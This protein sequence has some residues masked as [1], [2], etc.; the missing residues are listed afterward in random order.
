MQCNAASSDGGISIASNPKENHMRDIN[1]FIVAC[2]AFT[3]LLIIPPE[4]RCQRERNTDKNPDQ[5]LKGNARVN[6]STLA[7]EMSILLGTYPGRA[8]ISLSNTLNYSS[9]VWQFREFEAGAFVNMSGSQG[10]GVV[11]FYAR[12]T[13]AGW[14]ST[15]AA[16]RIDYPDEFPYYMVGC[17]ADYEGAIWS[18]IDYGEGCYYD[19]YYMKR[20][21]VVMPGGL[22]HELRASDS[23][24]QC[25]S[26]GGPCNNVD[27]T[28]T[29]LS[30]D[31]SRM[32]LEVTTTGATLF[33]PDGS[34][35]LFGAASGSVLGQTATEIIDVHGNKLTYN[36]TAREWTDTIGRVLPNPLP[37]NLYTA[38][39]HNHNQQQTVG[40]QIVS[41]PGLGSET[42]EAT[43]SW[44]YLK[45]PSSS[46]PDDSGL[47]N[48]SLDLAYPADFY[49]DGPYYYLFT[50]TKLFFNNN[51]AN[52]RLCNYW[53][54]SP[55]VPFNPVVLTKVTIASGQSYQFKYNLYGEIEKI[56][57][58]S[59]GYERF[60]YAQVT[61]LQNPTA[62]YE[63][64]NRGVTDQYIS[65]NGDGT[66]EIHWTYSASRSYNN[67]PI[68][69]TDPYKVTITNPDGTK[70]E[71]LIH[72]EPDYWTQRPFGFDNAKTG[73][74][75]DEKVYS[76]DS[77]PV[78][79]SRTLTA[80]ETTGPLSGGYSSAATRDIRPTKVISITFEPGNSS[81]LAT[82]SET[83]YDTTGNSD[84]A[85]FSSLNAKQIKKY[86]YVVVSSSTAATATITTAA[87]WFPESNL[88]TLAEM[89]YL[90]DPNYKVRNING[91]VAETR[92]KD[93]N[94][95]VKAKSQ[96]AYDEAAYPV[97]PA[98]TNAQWENPNTIYRGN[99]TTTRS[100]SDVA[101]NQY[102][103]THAQYDNFGNLRKAWDA[104]GNLT[105]TDF[106][107]VYA[108][109]Y[110]SSVTT[111]IPDPSGQNGSN[112]AL[113]TSTVYDFNTGLPTSTTDV[114]SQTRT[115]EY[116]DPLLR[117]TKIIASNGQQAITEYGAG[118]SASTRWVK[119]KTQLD[120]EKWQEGYTW[121]DGL[122]RT[123]KTQSVDNAGD[124]FVETEYDNMGRPKKVTNPYRTGETIYW[125]ESFYDDLGRVTKV[126]TPDNAEV[127]TTYGLAT[128]GSEIGTAVTISDQ[129]GKLRRS[130]TNALGHLKRIDEPNDAGQLGSIDNPNQWT[131]Y[132]Y[133][134]LNNLITVN[135]D[136][137]T[138]SFTYDALSRLKSA[139]NPENGLIQ[140][141][142]DPN[143]N[144]TQ[145]TDARGIVT[146]Y[147]YD[148]LNRVK[149]RQYTNEPIGSETPDVTYFYDNVTNAKGR[150]IK[151]SS[152]V[153]TTEYVT[154]DILGRVTRSKQITDG[155]VYGDDANPM[156]YTYNL[157]GALIEQKYPSGRAVKNV[158][159]NNGD[160]SIVE[161]KKNANSGFWHY[162]DSFTYNAAGAVTSMQL[163]NGRWES[164]IFNS[165]LQPTQIA[166]GTTQS[167]TD[168]LKLEY[169]YGDWVSGSIDPT[170]NNGNIVQQI[171]TAPTVTIG[172]TTYNGF[173]AMQKYYYDSLNRIDDATEEIS[174]SQTWRQDFI[175]DRYGNRNFVEANTTTLPKLCNGNT[176]MC[177][178]DRKIYNPSKN[179]SNNRLSTSDNYSFDASGNTTGDAE[180]RTFIFD[181][182]SKQVEVRNSSS[183]IIG[184][185]WYDGDG[186]R[187]KKYVP[188]TGETTVF[189]YDAS[190]KL[191]AEY[192][193]IVASTNDA[194]VAYLTNDHLG[195][196]RINT[197]ANGAVTAR[198]DYH[199]FGEEITTS[200][201]SAHIEYAGDSIRKQ[202]TGYER[203]SETSL[204]YAKARMFG[205][206]FGRFT[207]PDPLLSSGRVENPQTW[208][209][210]AYVLNN[211]LLFSDPLGLFE[212]A[213]SAGGS[214]TD[215][216][217][218]ARSMDRSL[219][220]RERRQARRQYQFRQ[221]FRAGL[222]R[223][224]VA[225]TSDRLTAEQ[226]Q[227]VQESVDSYGNENED[228]G[229]NVGIRVNAR[230]EPI[231]SGPKA[232][233]LLN[234]DDTVSVDFRLGRSADQLTV[235]IAHEGRHVADDLAWVNAGH[236]TGGDTDLNHYFRE[237]RAWNVSSYV[238][239]GLNLKKVS[240]GSDNSGKS[241][242]VW[243]RGWKAAE[244]ETKRA[245][246]INNILTY[247]NLK[248][249]D[250]DTFSNEHTHRP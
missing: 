82:M 203:D 205:S 91:L 113:N 181:A 136:V 100:W 222:E 84:S 206:G 217:L 220:K 236:P 225:A 197:D 189:V 124:V 64:T 159:D 126:K 90:Y 55:G 32:R 238:G 241:Y 172:S 44:R 96:I 156:T 112:T 35:V 10:I 235:T 67:P 247:S 140:Y 106:S 20:L 231:T 152:T 132:S 103:E 7:M 46:D 188:S 116:N 208:N 215:G 68:G 92:A 33:T 65:E 151:V 187:I 81:A 173:T 138:R 149:T 12:G 11:P 73:R 22:T 128:A 202:F 54:S 25:G 242:K 85:Y 131:G 17:G 39:F 52:V 24:I 144:L 161:S 246:G 1:H 191:V 104:E 62:P 186:R 59:G 53:T 6:P 200:Q 107:S 80:Y 223:A 239:Q 135:Q 198:H 109:A 122:T 227:Q 209:R 210:Y 234:A 166:L 3:L 34:R 114:N 121:F 74:H 37:D 14:T 66:D 108:Y 69:Q 111:P 201:R 146:S 199:P 61:G 27:L 174:S 105:Q 226:R 157:A 21:R 165:R 204:D 150:L 141:S 207:S 194:K 71:R 36:D 245:N 134:L 158:L 4:T 147:A 38:G 75:Y 224:R 171:I 15:L 89:D 170:K 184:Q 233:T 221:R 87:G 193:T 229:V 83:V 9:K 115:I 63:Q 58:P 190:G 160:L 243:S 133:D 26:A 13:A 88:A 60:V 56:I 176:E 120:T 249:T 250:T 50:G 110:P 117:P 101:A 153:S 94:G 98:G 155:V 23:P 212:W 154:F 97:I 185:Y 51:G 180:S 77:T 49:C 240:A 125:T 163:G 175:Y 86:N 182:E 213:E 130:I 5:V 164:T 129:A 45:H 137:Q 169:S 99:P 218:L 29:Y 143:G 219:T 192:S 237:Q 28:G 168:R 31:G 19:I 119:V 118:T 196:P 230:G 43:L 167:A 183:Q 93:T 48:T 145:K 78:L 248:S 2:I 42:I 47:G 76:S 216:Q 18:N 162:A 195:S 8:G 70:T 148:A 179:T 102:V 41:L 139:T 142:Y 127:N 57:Y 211:P 95:N 40:D 228:N 177:S 232:T 178:A 244:I 123:I 214:A 16:P 72:D 30:V 79:L